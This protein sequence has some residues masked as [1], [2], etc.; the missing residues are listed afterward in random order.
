MARY[1]ASLDRYYSVNFV[2]DSWREALDRPTD[3]L[4]LPG[5]AGVNG[6]GAGSLGTDGAATPSKIDVQEV[7]HRVGRYL[8]SNGC[9]V[10]VPIAEAMITYRE[11]G[12]D[13]ESTQV[14]IPFVSEVRIGISEVAVQSP[15]AA[16]ASAG[17]VLGSLEPD[18]LDGQQLGGMQIV[19]G[20]SSHQPLSVNSSFPSG[21]PPQTSPLLLSVNPLNGPPG[22]AGQSGGDRGEKEGRE[23]IRDKPNKITPPSSPNISSMHGTKDMLGSSS[24][25]ESVE[26]QVD[27]WLSGASAIAAAAA[28]RESSAA[29]SATSGATTIGGL[30]ATMAQA[31]TKSRGGGSSSGT[32]G[33]DGKSSAGQE[34]SSV[35][36]TVKAGFRW[37]VVQRL[38]NSGSSINTSSSASGDASS[39][40]T[41]TFGLK[42]KKQKIMRLGKKKS[43]KEK[44]SE[45][46]KSQVV[47][48]INRL[49]C[50]AKTHHSLLKVVIDGV[51]WN[52]V[53]FFQLS[54]QWQT[55]IRHFPVALFT[56]SG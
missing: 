45:A 13:E 49:V 44:E 30:A 1:L 5:G 12:S 14:F 23:M 31:V 36:Y 28:A 34:P 11:P 22:S 33:G 4:L 29:S 26:L 21:S 51:E 9:T 6:I 24:S 32:G 56:E 2:S 40:F 46:S 18:L 47:E 10:Q 52:N 48:G 55:H 15:A 35:K 38:P 19:G 50:Q 41:M 43:E 7:I 25:G 17:L 53:K 8:T 54:S 3:K 42:E 27:Y 16:A 37:I 20:G 39:L